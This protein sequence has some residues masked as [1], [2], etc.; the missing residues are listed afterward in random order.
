MEVYVKI[1]RW[2]GQ[3]L[4]AA[5]D[6]DVLGRTLQDS[7]IVFE[8]KEEFY[9]GFKT[10]LEEAVNLIEKSTI[11]NL[12]GSKIVKKAIERGYV[13]PEAVIEI[14]GVLHAQIVKM[15]L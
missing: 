9:K 15:Q 10:N 7:D 2:G 8:V 4:L 11:V 13:H 5:C 3:V 6:A 1:R 12:V 14:S